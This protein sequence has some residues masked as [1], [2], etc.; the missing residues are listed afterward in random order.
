MVRVE[1]PTGTTRY[2]V[3]TPFNSGHLRV[4][5][6]GSI[7][8]FSTLGRLH[9]LRLDGSAPTV[10]AKAQSIDAIAWSRDGSE[11][12]FSTTQAGVNADIRAVSPSSGRE[13]L[14]LA[15]SVSSE[16][17]DIAGSGRVLL[18]AT[19]DRREMAGLFPGESRERDFSLFNWSYPRDFSADGKSVLF[20]ELSGEYATY[21]RRTDGSPAVR[22]GAGASQALSPNGRWA[23]AIRPDAEQLVVLPTGAGDARMLPKGLIKHVTA[24]VVSLPDNNRILFMGQERDDEP[25]RIYVQDVERGDPRAVSPVGWVLGF[26]VPA[27]SRSFTAV[28]G[29]EG[30]P[31][32]GQLDGG[33]PIAIAGLAPRDLPLRWSSDG[34]VLYVLERSAN[35]QTAQLPARVFRLDT[36]THE[37][38]LWKTFAPADS[39]GLRSIGLVLPTPDGR[40]YVYDYQRSLSELFLVA[41]LR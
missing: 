38:T 16:V 18:G 8:A 35:G 11:V 40:Y 17:Y 36:G 14:V 6:A 7:I 41:G 34:R 22:L 25:R 29:D 10:V 26:A 27:D 9:I 12:W 13:R 37:R 39:A 2:E 15:Q 24:P 32:I 1:Y 20:S 5:P 21:L 19:R 28:I 30:T 33:A 31:V 3:G 23:V 4:S